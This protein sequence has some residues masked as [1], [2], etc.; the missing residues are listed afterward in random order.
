MAA[1]NWND[2]VVNVIKAIWAYTAG[3]QIAQ[4]VNANEL[5]IL[6]A[7]GNA[8]KYVRANADGTAFELASA[9]ALSNSNP[10]VNYRFTGSVAGGAFTFNIKQRDG[11]DP[12][13]ASPSRFLIGS[14]EYQLTTAT[15]FTK[16]GGT[17]WMNLGRA[18][19]AL[20]DV[21]VFVY[22]IA[23]TG[24]AAGLKF[25]F[26]RQPYAEIMGQFNST[27]TNENYIVGNYTNFNAGDLVVNIGRYRVQLSGG[28]GYTWNA[29]GSQNDI[30]R[31]YY[32]TDWLQYQPAWSA[33]GA[34]TA[35]LSAL[36][37]QRYKIHG[38]SITY[39]FSGTFTLGGT[40]SNF[41]YGT[42]V[43]YPLDSPVAIAANGENA[44]TVEMIVGR[45]GPS[46]NFEF[47][48]HTGANWT[49]P[50]CKIRFNATYRMV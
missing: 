35:G 32:E 18:E 44:G 13:P 42:S 21:D 37:H 39:Q 50:Q 4:S 29:R 27:P 12:T 24:A 33:S 45:I 43:W 7:S 19:L 11:T 23:E 41:I 34:M 1:A 17:N 36:D 20:K 16:T 22:A 49:L 5:G 25:G 3:G 9:E 40:A 47:Q 10:G 30:F 38:R 46:G 28:A 26:A 2:W 6:A 15:S 8:R 48:R 31:P 14:T